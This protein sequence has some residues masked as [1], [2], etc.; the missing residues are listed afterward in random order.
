MIRHGGAYAVLLFGSMVAPAVLSGHAH[1]AGCRDRT[2]TSWDIEV[3]PNS[4]P[5]ERLV[6]TGRVLSRADRSPLAGITVYVYHADAKG[7]YQHKGHENEPPRLCGILRTNQRGE[8]RIRTSM[9]GG[10]EGY[11][12]HI[13][14]EIWGLN[15]QRQ[16]AFVN[17]RRESGAMDT[18]LAVMPGS[19]PPLR[20]DRAGMTRPVRRGAGGVLTCTRDLMVEV[21]AA[22]LL[23]G[24]Q[25]Q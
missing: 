7:D 17:L 3:A 6:V 2:P 25:K 15:V 24:D 8:Y 22:R 5:G 1:A 9:P 20:E 13:H 19:D 12:P 23:P 11:A 4:E 14:F 21:K 10:Y 16:P 18:V